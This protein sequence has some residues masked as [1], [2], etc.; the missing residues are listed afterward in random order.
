MLL[1]EKRELDLRAEAIGKAIQAIDGT[2]RA[3]SRRH[4]SAVA[5]R[6][7]SLAQKKRWAAAGK[8]L[9]PPNQRKRRQRRFQRRLCP[10]E[11]CMELSQLKPG[12]AVVTGQVYGREERFLRIRKVAKVTLTGRQPQVVLDNGDR[13][14]IETGSVIGGLGDAILRLATQ[15]DF[16][17]EQGQRR[18]LEESQNQI[19]A[20]EA[21]RKELAD[22]FPVA[23]R[24]GIVGASSNQPGYFNLEFYNVPEEDIR[25]LAQ[26]LKSFGQS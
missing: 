16:D 20:N 22:L 3:G 21:H 2:H 11:G 18:K 10:M 9:V 15:A 7:I 25:N 4:L 17:R 1:N 5:R 19:A 23:I 6:K 13:Y 24:P 14:K 8:K 12:D 26:L